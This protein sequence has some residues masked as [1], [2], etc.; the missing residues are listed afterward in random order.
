M[1]HLKNEDN[2]YKAV[3][4]GKG[5]DVLSD[6]FFVV[7]DDPEVCENQIKRFKNFKDFYNYLGGDIYDNSCYWQLELSDEM[8]SEYNLDTSLMFQNDHIFDCQESVEVPE[9]TDSIKREENHNKVIYCFNKLN[10]CTTCQEIEKA[11]EDLTDEVPISHKDLLVNYMFSDRNNPAKAKAIAEYNNKHY[12]NENVYQEMMFAYEPDYVLPYFKYSLGSDSTNA[13][14]NG[15]AKRI[16]RYIKNGEFEVQKK[17]YYD[18]RTMFYCDQ[19]CATH[20]SDINA[21]TIFIRYFESLEAFNEYRDG[22]MTNCSFITDMS[23]SYNKIKKGVDINGKFFVEEVFF[24]KNG[25]ALA[26]IKNE[27]DF[28]FDFVYYLKGDLSNAD[29]I[30]CDGLENIKNW[31]GINLDGAK[32][33]SRISDALGMSYELYEL[34]CSLIKGSKSAIDNEK[35]SLPELKINRDLYLEALDKDLKPYQLWNDIKYHS[36]SYVSD[37]HLEHRIKNAKC[38]NDMDIIRC[39]RDLIKSFNG[40]NLTNYLL[41]GGD[42]ASDFNLFKFFVEELANTFPNIQVIFTLG[43]HEL[44]QFKGMTVDEITEKYRDF[45]NS[46]G[47]LLLQNTLFCHSDFGDKILEYDE[48][49][50]LSEEQINAVL[51]QSRFV[52]LGGLGFCGYDEEYN[53][54]KG[55]YRNVITREQEINETKK[56]ETL[57]NKLLPVLKQH[58][59]VVFT[60]TPK[61]SW[62]ADPKLE[63]GVIYV[64]GHNHLNRFYDDG[65]T[66]LYADNQ[67]GYKGKHITIKYFM[68]DNR[69]DTFNTYADGIYSISKQQYIDFMKGKS[70][71]MTFSRDLDIFML[72]NN[73]LYCFISR[74]SGGNLCVL[75]KGSMKRLE[76]TDLKFYYENMNIMADFLIYSTKSISSLLKM[77]SN[78]IKGIGGTG[79]VHG[80]IVDIDYKNHI[81]VNPFDRKITAYWAADMVNKIVYPSVPDLL[82]SQCPE[83]YMNYQNLLENRSPDILAFSNQPHAYKNVAYLHTDIYAAS[84]KMKKIQNLDDGILVCWD[85]KHLNELISKHLLK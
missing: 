57:Y 9:E 26:T 8:K 14:H 70:I 43:N 22:D 23:T 3:V 1:K 78:S 34:D 60:H 16:A 12:E 79:H 42:T 41:I 65:T 53:A 56:F 73:G 74:S 50:Q 51:Y 33:T 71:R 62:C 68:L 5:Y 61:E 82:E 31:D 29:L 83:L 59:S 20:P 7:E 35:K 13:K 49:Q 17:G 30:M 25:E 27:F 37:I 52:M 63:D 81:Y 84:R 44:W 66:R 28:F 19:I 54:N 47:M 38:R 40:S 75:N 58:N 45:L 64:N 21:G 69:Y 85:E 11:L 24:N 36:F 76:R 2:D 72:K 48:L 10:Q 4:C 80:C 55:Y 32:Y 6:S 46:K 67:I 39:I 15:R 18:D 77:V